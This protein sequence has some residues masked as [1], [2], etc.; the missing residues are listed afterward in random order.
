ALFIGIKAE[1]PRRVLAAL[2]PKMLALSAEKADGA[3]PYNVTPEHTKLA[4]EIL[5]DG[6][7][8]IVEQKATL[9]TNVAAARDTARQALA[10]YTGLPNYVNNWRRL[11]FTDDDFAGGGSDRL[12]DAMV[13]HGDEAA[14]QARVQA[15]LDAG[16][17]HVAVQVLPVG[18]QFGI[19]RDEWRRLAPA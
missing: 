12:L 19:A 8:L 1:R 6:K 9:T 17:D 10:V 2:G 7:L 14:I 11:G 15:H 16:A 18:N 4:R 13:V 3:Q 5:G